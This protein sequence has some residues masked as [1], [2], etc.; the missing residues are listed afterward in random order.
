[1]GRNRRW[2]PCISHTGKEAEDFIANYFA[3]PGRKV[4][5]IAGAGFDPRAT[6]V[7][8]ELARA[9]GA[10]VRAILFRENR[11][12]PNATLLKR[13]EANIAELLQIIPAQELQQIEI[14]GADGAVTGG[15]NVVNALGKADLSDAS[16]I[17]VDASALSVGTCYPIVGYLMRSI[18]RKALTGNLHLL[19]AHDATLDGLIRSTPSDTPG[20]VHGF[21]GAPRWTRRGGPPSF[22]CPNWQPAAEARLAGCTPLSNP[23]IPV[24]FWH[25]QRACR[26]WPIGW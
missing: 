1:M 24:R 25:S 12:K 15:R 11:P 23:M 3:E 10:N 14:F 20:Y 22:G 26:A 5:L 19:V 8:K 21:K 2:D 17:V 16:D 13:A 7:A 18:E 4:A 9:A 6:A